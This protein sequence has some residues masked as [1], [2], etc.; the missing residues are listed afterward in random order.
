MP[1]HSSQ[2]LR[3][4]LLCTSVVVAIRARLSAWRKSHT[5]LTGRDPDSIRQKIWGS[6]AVVGPGPMR[7]VS[8]MWARP[9][10]VFATSYLFHQ[11]SLGLLWWAD[12]ASFSFKKAGIFA[13]SH[14]GRTLPGM[15]L[16]TLSHTGLVE[17]E[18]IADT[19]GSKY[20]SSTIPTV[21]KT[22]FLKQWSIWVLVAAD[23]LR[24]LACCRSSEYDCIS[25]MSSGTRY[26]N[27]HVGE[28]SWSRIP[29]TTFQ[30]WHF[31]ISS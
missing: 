8:T 12:S 5:P 31:P 16:G 26:C 28:E 18:P 1:G 7:I 13:V 29:S 23:V 2:G 14:T 3:G 6:A 17:G 24:A 25:V 30:F 20:V 4:A 22:F 15:W 9:N 10:P 21:T 27:S 11:G 19:S